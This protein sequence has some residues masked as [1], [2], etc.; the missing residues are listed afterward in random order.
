MSTCSLSSNPQGLCARNGYPHFID[1][2]NEAP[3]RGV[4]FLSSHSWQVAEPGL[5]PS[6]NTRTGALKTLVCWVPL[7][8]QH[9]HAKSLQS[10]PTLRDPMD[11]SP[12]GS[13][14]H[15]ILQAGILEWVAIS[16][17]RGS[18]QTRV[19]TLLSY[20]S[21]LGRQGLYHVPD[22]GKPGFHLGNGKH[23][24]GRKCSGSRS[25]VHQRLLE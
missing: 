8:C 14:V 20:V 17:S 7:V 15:G 2:G 22:Y 11:C 6:L 25:G 23:M 18:S 19:Q 10:R 21:C 16:S 5:E 1:V 9:V 13:S 3:R 24:S 4:A 12:P